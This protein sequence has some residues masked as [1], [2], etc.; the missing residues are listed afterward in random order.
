MFTAFVTLVT[1][2]D[3]QA[4]LMSR[5]STVQCFN[6]QPPLGVAPS[7]RFVA[8][9]CSTLKSHFGPIKSM[10]VA[11]WHHLQGGVPLYRPLRRSLY[12]PTRR[13]QD[14]PRPRCIGPS[15]TFSGTSLL[16]SLPAYTKTDNERFK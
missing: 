2:P 1:A 10:V 15:R 11:L 4:S 6:V 5:A 12:R 9:G 13:Q 3:T 7:H 8:P 16:R 14:R